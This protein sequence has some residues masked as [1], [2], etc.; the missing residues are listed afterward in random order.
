MMVY[1]KQSKILNIKPKIKIMSKLLH[2]QVEK[3]QNAKLCVILLF[4]DI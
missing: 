1:L 3:L 2:V 4:V